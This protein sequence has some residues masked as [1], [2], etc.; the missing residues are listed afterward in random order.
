MP[1]LNHDSNLRAKV[2]GSYGASNDFGFEEGAD[3]KTLAKRLAAGVEWAY[4]GC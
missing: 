3:P 1:L 2:W 4:L